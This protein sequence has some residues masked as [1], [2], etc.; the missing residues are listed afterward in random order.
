VIHTDDISWHHSFFGWSDVLIDGLLEPLRR[1]GPPLSFTPGA[2]TERGRP[3]AI[4]LPVGTR[5]VLVE[6]VGAGRRKLMPWL[7]ATVW[8]QTDEAVA[9]ERTVALD[10]DP[11]GFVSDW[12]EAERAHLDRDQPWT[13]SCAIVS[14]ERPMGPHRELWV[15]FTHDSPG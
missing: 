11:P 4:S 12:M 8:V 5:V 1:Q 13:R 6:G 10:R 15:Q 9:M 3:G 7:D 2:W 14:G